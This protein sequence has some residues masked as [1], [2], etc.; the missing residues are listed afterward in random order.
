MGTGITA[1]ITTRDAA[2]SALHNTWRQHRQAPAVCTPANICQTEPAAS[3]L[4]EAI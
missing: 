3:P 2:I 4:L 1:E